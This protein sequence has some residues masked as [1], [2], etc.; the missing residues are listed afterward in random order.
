[1]LIYSGSGMMEFAC[2]FT[3]A[4][5]PLHCTLY[6]HAP[7]VAPGALSPIVVVSLTYSISSS[8]CGVL[9]V[10]VGS[11]PLQEHLWLDC[12]DQGNPNS[13]CCG[14]SLGLFGSLQ[15][16]AGILWL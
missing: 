14:F 8:V 4:S 11:L 1:M 7:P 12:T 3:K 2:P 9:V 10:C 5:L 16:R 13:F 15:I 6:T